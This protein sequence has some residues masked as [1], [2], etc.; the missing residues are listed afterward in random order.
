MIYLNLPLQVYIYILNVS[1]ILLIGLGYYL[2]KKKLSPYFKVITIWLLL[3]IAFNF[4]N[5]RLT[6]VN[7]IKNSKKVGPKGIRGDIGPRGYTGDSDVCTNCLPEH[8]YY[9]G[10]RNADNKLI[11]N[12][13]IKPGFCKLPFSF[14]NELYKEPIKSTDKG[15]PIIN[16]IPLNDD[17]PD[18]WCAT[19]V[20]DDLTMKKYGYVYNSDKNMAELE[21][22]KKTS[23]EEK[24]YIQKKSGI[25]DLEL[26]T[27]VRSS[28][29]C[30][31]G[32]TKLTKDLNSN[33]DGNYVYLCNKYGIDDV[34]VIDVKIIPGTKTC[35]SNYTELK[36]GLNEGVPKLATVD[37]LKMCVAKGDLN[38][39]PIIKDITIVD[40]E[41][42]CTN[43]TFIKSNLNIGT[44]GDPLYLCTTTDAIDIIIDAAFVWSEDNNLYFFKND[45]YWKFTPK[46]KLTGPFLIND[47]WGKIIGTSDNSV[48]SLETTKSSTTTTTSAIITEPITEGIDAIY[49]DFFDNLTYIFKGNMVY[50]YDPQKERI[51]AGFPKKIN[52]I[53]KGLP[54]NMEFI[55][56]VY[57]DDK[58]ETIYFIKNKLYYK[59]T[60]ANKTFEKAKK[61]SNLWINGPKNI[62][63]KAMFNFNKKRY[64]IESDMVYEINDDNTFNTIGAKLLNKVFTTLTL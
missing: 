36:V 35:P 41:S 18:G 44:D 51:K 17:G 13:L 3:L 33:T 54:K 1:F 19:E 59:L 56:S 20:N 52:D 55:D 42:K 39:N 45:Q 5:M 34:G 63:I 48:S 2:N 22:N 10:N 21:Q 12:E 29:Q 58:N 11:E 40:D 53:W 6:L 43:G 4:Y 32:F 50:A 15:G 46:K 26:I 47:F 9:G 62:I 61:I 25:V 37:K 24:Q 14:N 57:A 64:I 60:N 23:I 30:P 31:K 8:K 27:G 49:S 28:V 16:G 38:N 7:Y